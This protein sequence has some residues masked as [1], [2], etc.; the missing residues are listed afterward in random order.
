MK[1][2]IKNKFINSCIEN[3]GNIFTQQEIIKSLEKMYNKC[4]N[5]WKKDADNWNSYMKALSE[6]PG[7]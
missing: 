2:E 3:D 5:L 1:D 6:N 4:K 7:S